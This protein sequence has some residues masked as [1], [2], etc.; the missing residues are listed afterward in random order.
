[1]AELERR[2]QFYVGE[3]PASATVWTEDPAT[4]IPQRSGRGRQPTQPVRDS[5]RSV[6]DVADSLPAESWQ[7]LGLREGSGEPLVFEFATVRVWAM[8]KQKPGPPIG[9]LI[10]RPVGGG[11][12]DV[13]Y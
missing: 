6:K 5:V 3:V 4:Q 2:K 10:R 11:A 9:V 1:M 12:G 8:R 7:V 13:K